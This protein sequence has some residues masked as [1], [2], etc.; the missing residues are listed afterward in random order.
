MMCQLKDQGGLGIQNL[1]V[2]NECLL[3]KWLFKL[4]NEDFMKQISI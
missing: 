2:H 4:I 3:N 1:K